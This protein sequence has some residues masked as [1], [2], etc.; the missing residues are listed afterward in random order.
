MGL[1]I[2]PADLNSL[3]SCCIVAGRAAEALPSG[4]SHILPS[5]VAPNE[6]DGPTSWLM[7]TPPVAGDP[8]PSA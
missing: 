7:W 8:V 6:A 3:K 5:V 1:S 4:S 2:Q